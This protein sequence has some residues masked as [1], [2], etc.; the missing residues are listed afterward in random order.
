M[1]TPTYTPLA[2]ITLSSSAASVTFSSISQAYRDLVL[3]VSAAGTTTG[4]LQIRVNGDSGSNYSYVGMS[5]SGTTTYSYSGTTT[6]AYIN[7]STYMNTTPGFMCKLD[8][9]DYSATDK[10]KAIL[11]RSDDARA[12]SE[13][14]T[15]RWANTAAITSIACI[16]TATAF[17]AGSTFSLYGIAS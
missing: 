17:A 8:F 6:Y 15:V 10:H 16:T 1:P 11:L 4:N 3:V 5:G 9:Q 2:E 7:Y 14:H 12:G 13:A